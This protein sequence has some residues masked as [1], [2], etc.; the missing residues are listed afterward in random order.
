M[1]VSRRSFLG[2]GAALPLAD[3]RVW[4]PADDIPPSSFDPWVEVHGGHL[5][6]NVEAVHR[7]VG[8]RPVMAVVKNDGY[9]TGIANVGR[10]LD[11][12]PPVAGMAVVKLHEAVTL[13]DAGIRKPVLLMG[14]FDERNL[15]DAVARSVTCMVYTPIG[16]ALER[17]AARLQ[18]PVDV[19]VCVDTGIGRVGVPVPRAAALIRDLAARHGVRIAGTMMTFTE[20]AEFDREQLRRFREL[21]AGL[22][23]E[24][25]SLG[26]LHAASSY[27]LFQHPDAFLDMVRPG[28]ALY[29]IYPEP[30]FRRAGVMDLVPA[31]SLK[32]RVVY[33]KRLAEG[34]SAGYNRAYVAARDVWV[35]TLPVGHADGWPRTAARGASV[36]SGGALYPI[37]ASVSASHT[38][39]EIGDEARVAIGDV[40]TFF[41]WTDGSRPEDVG[42]ACGASVY[43]LTMHLNPLLPRRLV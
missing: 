17:V 19:H 2:S 4:R 35:A 22:V 23:S 31:L 1:A 36:R 16:D 13:R 15:A 33:V 14:P 5:R 27:G 42:A 41:D 34:E 25:V 11:G 37:V 26:P 32:A 10:V 9:G 30:E 38:I 21:C 12:L 20:D 39:V 3:L 6:R 40:A 43:D 18:K 28:M 8:G 7:R 24:G 29:G